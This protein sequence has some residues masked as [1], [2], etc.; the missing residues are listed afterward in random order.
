MSKNIF[1]LHTG[2]HNQLAFTISHASNVSRRDRNFWCTCELFFLRRN[3][4]GSKTSEVFE[5]GYVKCLNLL[6][7]NSVIPQ[8]YNADCPV[9]LRVESYG[10]SNIFKG[11]INPSFAR[12]KLRRWQFQLR[13]HEVRPLIK[14]ELVSHR[15]P[16]EESSYGV[17]KSGNENTNREY[18]HQSIGVFGVRDECPAVLQGRTKL[19]HIYRAAW[20]GMGVIGI[21]AIVCG[22]IVLT[23]G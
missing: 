14:F 21:I 6:K 23:I 20:L 7:S 3:C 18:S 10:F 4:R 17:K 1:I 8:L 22:I 15:L 13:G 9:R 16:L 11:Q 2:D 12:T 19:T 5:R